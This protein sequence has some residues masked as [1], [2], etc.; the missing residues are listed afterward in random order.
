MLDLSEQ[1]KVKA[2]WEEMSQTFRSYPE[3]VVRVPEPI[4]GTAFFPGG[5]GLLLD[6][7]D[8]PQS[9]S[10]AD[11]MVVGHDFN[12]FA[13]YEN[14]RQKGTEFF[15]SQTWRNIRNAFPRLGL[16]LRKCFF[17]NFLS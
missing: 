1:T 11:V 7:S 17:T 2:L 6:Q 16:S 12:T 14:A 10:A 9:D 13:T 8:E 4:S 5:L 15:I 3:G